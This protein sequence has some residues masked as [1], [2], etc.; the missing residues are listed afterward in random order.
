MINNNKNER[1]IIFDNDC[2]LLISIHVISLEHHHWR[3]RWNYPRLVGKSHNCKMAISENTEITY[4]YGDTYPYP[5]PMAYLYSV[6]SHN[7]LRRHHIDS[8]VQVIN[9]SIILCTT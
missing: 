9:C 3:A 6:E 4:I 8:I 2:T 5:M 1:V 7:C